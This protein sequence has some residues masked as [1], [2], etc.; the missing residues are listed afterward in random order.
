M[1]LYLALINDDFVLLPTIIVHTGDEPGIG[2][3]WLSMEAG[4]E[5]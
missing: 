2:I 5:W 1:N 3:A 4:I